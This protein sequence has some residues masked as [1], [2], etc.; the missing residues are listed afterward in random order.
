M[1]EQ[2][3]HLSDLQLDDTGRRLL[4]DAARWTQFLSI[5]FFVGGGFIVLAIL[6]LTMTSDYLEQSIKNTGRE[7][8]MGFGV[9]GMVLLM[10]A[11]LI[12]ILIVGWLL[13]RFSNGTRQGLAR[14]DV[15]KTESGIAALKNYFVLYGVLVILSALMSVLYFFI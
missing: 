11:C 7:L 4:R 15:Q 3:V 6:G 10:I 14:Q 5:V 9:T 12:F 2:Q 8:Y 13:M 1:E